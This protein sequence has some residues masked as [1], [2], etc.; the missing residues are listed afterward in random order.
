MDKEISAEEE[1]FVVQK[2]SSK[3]KDKIIYDANL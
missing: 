1:D 3:L 2:L